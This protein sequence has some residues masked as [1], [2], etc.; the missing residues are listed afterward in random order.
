M[1]RKKGTVPAAAP[2]PAPAKRYNVTLALKTIA[3]DAADEGS[4]IAEA[5]RTLAA[6]VPA[7]VA[8]STV[9]PDAVKVIGF[10]LPPSGPTPT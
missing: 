2:S 10:Q 9:W 4:A 8:S 6:D 3:V 1:T 5:Q 7:Q